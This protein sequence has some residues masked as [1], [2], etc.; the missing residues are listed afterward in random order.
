[1]NKALSLQK[2]V[3]AELCTIN[4]NLALG[5]IYDRMGN[6][7]I[8]ADKNA[9]ALDAFDRAI[10]IYEAD[11]VIFSMYE[12]KSRLCSTL[13]YATKVSFE[14]KD[15]DKI[16]YYSKKY[17][18]LAEYLAEKYASP[19][20]I[21]RLIEAYHIFATTKEEHSDAERK[22][23]PLYEKLCRIRPHDERYKNMLFTVTG[24]R[25]GHKKKNKA[26]KQ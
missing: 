6:F 4:T 9:E 18:E 26:K 3:V 7:Y 19:G 12:A 17:F 16:V 1:M 22:S 25:K 20:Q 8:N 23:L 5:Y 2:A 14:L 11:P 13:Y 21:Y 24:T 15:W 10:S